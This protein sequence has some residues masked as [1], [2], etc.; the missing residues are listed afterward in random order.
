MRISALRGRRPR[1]AALPTSRRFSIMPHFLRRH[2]SKWNCPAWL[3]QQVPQLGVLIFQSFSLRASETSM[4]PN[5][6]CGAHDSKT[7]RIKTRPRSNAARPLIGASCLVQR[8][9]SP[10]AATGLSKLWMIFARRRCPRH[11]RQA[12]RRCRPFPS[13]RGDPEPDHRQ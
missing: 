8:D 2:P 7:R 9:L 5:F 13:R 12:R 4:P 3:G 11:R 10:V 6:A 1:A